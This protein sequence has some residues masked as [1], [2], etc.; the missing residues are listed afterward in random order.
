VLFRSKGCQGTDT[1]NNGYSSGA[2]GTGATGGS[3]TRMKNV[4]V[5]FIIY[6]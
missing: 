1:N 6:V 5:M 4:A 3:E 2:N